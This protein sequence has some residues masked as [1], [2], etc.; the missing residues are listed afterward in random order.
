MSSLVCVDAHVGSLTRFEVGG[1]A[2]RRTHEYHHGE[3]ATFTREVVEYF[4][5]HPDQKWAVEPPPRPTNPP[6]SAGRVK[7]AVA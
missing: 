7:I 1:S 5:L 3:P 4:R 2:I 6:A